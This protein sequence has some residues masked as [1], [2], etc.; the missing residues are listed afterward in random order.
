MRKRVT[1]GRSTV[2]AECDEDTD[3]L[4]EIRIASQIVTYA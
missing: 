3:F 1:D 2:R 4:L